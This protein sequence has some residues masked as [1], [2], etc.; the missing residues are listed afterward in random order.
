MLD[1]ND[2]VKII[3][4]AATDAVEAAKPT[5]IC[6]GE[7]INDDPLEISIDQKITLDEDQLI[8]TNTIANAGLVI[9]DRVVLLREQGGQQYVVLDKLA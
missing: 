6:Y 9:S 2:L 5:A 3:K 4:K 7:V 1:G 8:L